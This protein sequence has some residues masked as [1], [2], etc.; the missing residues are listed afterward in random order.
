MEHE[1]LH[2]VGANSATNAFKHTE[3][4][5]YNPHAEAWT[6]AIQTIGQGEKLKGG[7]QYEVFPNKDCPT[8]TA[9]ESTIL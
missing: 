2:C 3:L 7:T 6:E 9:S 5:P 8:L 1:D 4:F